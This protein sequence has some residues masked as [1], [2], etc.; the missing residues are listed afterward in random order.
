MV[1]LVN[2]CVKSVE[3]CSKSAKV[4]ESGLRVQ[5][6]GRFDKGREKSVY[7]ESFTE[8]TVKTEV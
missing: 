5:E 6:A 4:S 1:L 2:V 3:G 8:N 7:M